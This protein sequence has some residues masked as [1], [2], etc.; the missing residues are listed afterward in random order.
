MDYTSFWKGALPPQDFWNR[1]VVA[2][3]S[4]RGWTF[5]ACRL[6]IS[7]IAPWS[8]NGQWVF[9]NSLSTA[10][11][12]LESRR[13]RLSAMFTTIKPA[14]IRLKISGI[15]PWSPVITVVSALVASVRLKISGIAPW[16]PAFFVEDFLRRGPPQDFWNRAVVADRASCRPCNTNSASRFLESRRGRLFRRAGGVLVT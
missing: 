4:L 9:G 10:S 8:P 2:V 16:S 6:K 15:A 5:T 3:V 7:G 14:S 12:F 1:A 13:G 11:R